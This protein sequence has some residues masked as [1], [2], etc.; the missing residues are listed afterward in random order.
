MS[1]STKSPFSQI[2]YICLYVSDLKE[3][4]KFY[5]DILGLELDTS[6]S[7]DSFFAFKTGNPQLA[8]EKG[9]VK[10]DSEKTKAEN[11]VLFQFLADTP[12]VLEEMNLVLE[13]NGVKLLKR[14]QTS[15]WGISTNFLDPDGNKLSIIYM[16]K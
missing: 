13:S 4:I 5:Q 2:G 7:T 3:S 9:G 6:V 1:D 15:S 11:P 16:Y 8:L 12:E 14:S 10:K